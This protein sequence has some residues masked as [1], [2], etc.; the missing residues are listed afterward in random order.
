MQTDS[1]TIELQLV[2]MIIWEI[3]YSLDLQ[4]MFS[5]KLLDSWVTLINLGIFKNLLLKT[6]PINLSRAVNHPKVTETFYWSSWS[7]VCNESYRYY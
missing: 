1:S 5:F 4:K 2:F 7:Q 3:L 6:V